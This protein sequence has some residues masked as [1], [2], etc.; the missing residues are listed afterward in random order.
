[1]KNIRAHLGRRIKSLRLSLEIT[2]DKLAETAGIDYKYLQKIESKHSPN[3]TLETLRKLA[4][5][6]KT[7]PSNL[8]DI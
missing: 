1:M 5:A 8:L 2:Q 4:K 7:T 6:L 3:L